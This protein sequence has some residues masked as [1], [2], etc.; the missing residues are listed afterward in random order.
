MLFKGTLLTQASGA[1]VGLVYSHNRGGAYI[2]GRSIPTNPQSAQQ[3][4]VRAFMAQLANVW[5]NVLT[6]AQREAWD[7]YATNTS[8]PNRVGDQINIGG[9][10]HYVRSNVPRLQAGL[11]RVDTAPVIFNVGDFTQ[12]T[13]ISLTA[14][15]EI[16]SIGFTNT[17][18]WATEVGSAMLVLGSRPQNSSI[19]FFKGPYQFAGTIP[20]AVMAPASP[21][22]ITMPFNFAVAQKGFLQFRVTRADGRLSEPFRLPGTAV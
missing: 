22:P 21:Q 8:R 19:N 11:A 13:V 20:G 14:A 7:V 1:A 10:G 16:A 4:V 17:D 15:T 5:R 2:R 6:A 12:P 3:V 9:V 18:A